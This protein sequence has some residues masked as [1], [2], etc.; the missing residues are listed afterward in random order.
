MENVALDMG[1]GTAEVCSDGRCTAYGG[2]MGGRAG[3]TGI[4]RLCAVGTA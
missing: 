3:W 2:Y 1:A 4:C